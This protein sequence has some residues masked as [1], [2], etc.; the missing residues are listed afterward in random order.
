MIL[1]VNKIK[2]VQEEKDLQNLEILMTRKR[3]MDQE[4]KILKNLV[5]LMKKI[6]IK[7][8]KIK[9][10]DQEEKIQKNSVILMKME[11]EK[12][13]K[14]VQ[15]EKNQKNLVILQMTMIIN[16]LRLIMD[17]WLYQKASLNKKNKTK[18]LKKKKNK[19]KKLKKKKTNKFQKN[20]K[21]TKKI[22]Q[23]INLEIEEKI[24]KKEWKLEVKCSL[25]K[26]PSKM[27]IKKLRINQITT[28]LLYLITN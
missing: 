18:K 8:M 3:K 15:V 25:N 12:T 11:M 1:L 9:K 21:L 4:E 22:M 20:Q 17:K 6:K 28:F 13:N 26:E 10:M 14:M 19:N 27:I 23:L 5:I 24:D 16:K 7:K 2:M